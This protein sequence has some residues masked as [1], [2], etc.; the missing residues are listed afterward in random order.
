MHLKQILIIEKPNLWT[1]HLK[2]LVK[3]LTFC[4]FKQKIKAEFKKKTNLENT[5]Q[6]SL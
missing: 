1:T 2:I 4:K 3:I 6:L 5:C